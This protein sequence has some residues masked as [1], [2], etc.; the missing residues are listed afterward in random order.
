MPSFTAVSF[1]ALPVESLIRTDVSIVFLSVESFMSL[2]IIFTVRFGSSAYSSNATAFAAKPAWAA[3]VV[4]LK[5][6]V[7]PSARSESFLS[8]AETNDFLE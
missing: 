7:K 4:A 8:G 3:A 6:S 2:A 5:F 1:V